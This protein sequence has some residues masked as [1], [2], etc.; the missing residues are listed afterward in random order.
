MAFIYISH[1]LEEIFE[2]CDNVTVMR[3]GRNMGDYAVGE[4]T[5]P[6]WCA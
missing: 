4:L 2:L 6:D 5:Q 3:D 1:Y